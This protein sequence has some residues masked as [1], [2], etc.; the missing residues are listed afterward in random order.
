LAWTGFPSGSSEF[1][2][3]S[4]LRTHNLE[5]LLHFSGLELSVKGTLL[6]EWSLATARWDPEVRYKPIGDISEAEAR[7]MIESTRELLKVL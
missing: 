5:T 6:S 4:S 2:E 1:R 3:L 7:G